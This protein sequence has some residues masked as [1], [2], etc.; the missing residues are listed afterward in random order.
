[1][2]ASERGQSTVLVMGMMV[3]C[4]AVAGVAVDGTRAFIFRRS[5]QNAAD[6]AAQAG[7]SQLDASVYYNSTGDEVLLD[8]RKARLAAERSLGIPGIPVSATFAI[9]GSSVQ[10][11]LRGEVRT[12][13][14]GLI[15]VGKLP[16]AVEARAEPI[17]GD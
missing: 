16:V 12:S 10:I 9:D 8:E 11:V 6:S 14:L 3:L 2:I 5:L 1:M 17:A 13:F 7:A 15:G 4:F